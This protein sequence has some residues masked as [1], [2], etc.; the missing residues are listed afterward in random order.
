MTVSTVSHPPLFQRLKHLMDFSDPVAKEL[1]Q[2]AS[3]KDW[4]WNES[5]QK[6]VLE[7]LSPAHYRKCSDH[8]KKVCRR[9]EPSQLH[10]LLKATAE[11]A[12]ANSK[13]KDPAIHFHRLSK[14]LTLEQIE[15]AIRTEY[16]TFENAL[17]AAK[18]LVSY[19]RYYN[20]LNHTPATKHAI[21]RMIAKVLFAIESTLDTMLRLF[22]F[23][24][25]QRDID[26]DFEAQ[27]RLQAMLA[28]FSYLST[29]VTLAITLAGSFL[30]G[31][32]IAGAG[33]IAGA[34]LLAVYQKWLKP[35]PRSI[36]GFTNLTTKARGGQLSGDMVGGRQRYLDEI[37]A[38]LIASDQKPKTHPL[39]I[40]PTGVGK[41]ELMRAFA[42]AVAEGRYPALK[43]KQVFYIN[44]ADLA[45]SG[46]GSF[47]ESSVTL[48]VIKE[49]LKGREKDVILIFDEIHQAC[50]GIIQSNLGERMKTLLD[51]EFPYVIGGTTDVEFARYVN[52]ALARRFKQIP[53][54]PTNKDQTLAILNKILLR[55]PGLQ[56]TSEAIEAAYE[57]TKQH[58]PDKPQPYMACRILSQAISKVKA[59]LASKLKSELEE[60]R[61]SLEKNQAMRLRKQGTQLLPGH[62]DN[63][64]LETENRKIRKRIE[65]LQKR[66]GQENKQVE[67]LKRLNEQLQTSKEELLKNSLAIDKSGSKK[68]RPL[69]KEFVE[70]SYYLHVAW[71]QAVKTQMAD[72]PSA[73]IDKTLIQEIVEGEVKLNAEKVEMLKKDKITNKVEGLHRIE[74]HALEV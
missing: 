7:A 10:K 40:G 30:T 34:A 56:A 58:F 50:R 8:L 18:E 29:L 48:D 32:A 41:T 67:Q 60:A 4:N 73:R 17:G 57:L 25:F 72:I 2:L 74:D 13:L 36:K 28:V 39:L 35:A 55:H 49:R 1:K 3:S 11:A 26:N 20:D 71:D 45:S 46:R 59:R 5:R 43:N 66:Y 69:L 44:T 38:A 23:Y 9:L 51:G 33:L 65:D 24:Q 21:N 16:P 64:A 14:L 62:S 52:E 31:L 54:E 19:A 27:H 15:A 37:A 12:P 42:C 61:A 53:I 6:L 47:F 22:G 63:A 70:N 68:V